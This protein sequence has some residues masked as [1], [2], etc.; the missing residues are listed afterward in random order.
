MKTDAPIRAPRVSLGMP[1]YNGGDWIA[2]AIDSSLGQTF[3][4]LEL[5]I[6][7]NAS[8]DETEAIVRPQQYFWRNS[9]S[10]NEPRRRATWARMPSPC[11]IEKLLSDTWNF[12]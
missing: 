5:I 3:G 2:E 1:V 4:D 10:R 11:E 6:C 12:A 9:I 7:D 8:T